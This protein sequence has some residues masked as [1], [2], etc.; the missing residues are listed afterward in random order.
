MEN[1]FDLL[2]QE[3]E[4]V[5]AK[6]AQKLL[7]KGGGIEFNNVNFNYTPDKTILKNVSFS[8]PPGKTVALVRYLIRVL[9]ILI[10]SWFC[11]SQVGPSGSGKSTII[12]LLFRFYDVDSGSIVIDGYNIKNQVTQ[13]SLRAIIGVVPQDTVLFNQTIK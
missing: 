13:E 7:P 12:K 9:L 11:S 8:V 4:V 3:Q 1:M 10:K 5:D 6:D 2:R